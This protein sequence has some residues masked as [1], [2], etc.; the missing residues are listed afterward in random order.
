MATN[1]KIIPDHS[2]FS[3]QEAEWLNHFLTRMSGEQAQWLSGFM[4]GYQ[5]SL[6]QGG[7]RNAT[8]FMDSGILEAESPTLPSPITHT[9]PKPSITILYGTE[10]GNS[11][12]LAAE[13]KKR[14]SKLGFK[15]R[16]LDMS[17]ARPTDLPTEENLMVIVST[18]GAGDPPERAADYHAKL[19]SQEAPRLDGLRYAV[20]GLGDSS[21]DQFCQMGKVFDARLEQLGG[22]RICDRRDCDTDYE[23]VA[24]SWMDTTLAAMLEHAR[25]S[26]P[27]AAGGSGTADYASGA[28][29]GTQAAPAEVYSIYGKKNPF[30]SPLLDRVVLNGTGSSKETLH[31]EFSLEDSGITYEPG[32]AIAILPVNCPE[33]IRDIIHAA[34]LSPEYPVTS[35]SGDPVDLESYI[36]K[37]CDA[38]SL[39]KLLIQKYHELSPNDELAELLRPESKAKLQ[40]FI[41]G[42]EIV[43][44]LVEY[45]IPNLSPDNLIQL[46]RRLPPRLYSIASSQRANPDQVHLTVAAVRYYT[47]RRNRKGV[48]STFLA[49][50]IGIGEKV[51]LYVQPNRHFR[52]PADPDVPII[53]VGPGTGIAPFR[54]FMQD[55][56]VTGAKGKNWLFYGDRH[57][58]TDFLYQLEWQDYHKDGLLTRMDVAFSRDT[59]ERIYVQHRML[60]HS[61]EIFGWLEEGACFYVCGDASRM[62]SD[63]HNTLID[64]VGREGN[65]NPEEASAYVNQLKKSNRY[66]RDVY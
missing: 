33:V 34:G 40:E 23:S 52:L 8:Q 64:I 24:S 31:L 42:R 2:P 44:L 26:V 55:R 62:A 63:V 57:F 36:L 7:M 27:V 53:M 10:S 9:P 3:P 48:C 30:P 28:S 59:P 65:K 56:Q 66:Q 46:F 17:D 12:S 47:H 35:K 45:P 22:K 49:D 19:M 20:L 15:A 25:A 60:E 51:P 6:L 13:A 50:R 38:T 61:R 4:S 18:W 54:A 58:S 41:W 14:A 16:M 1:R 39:S 11:E 21:Y 29:S 32:D 43:D 37:E 5:V